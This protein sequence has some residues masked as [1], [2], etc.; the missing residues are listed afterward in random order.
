MGNTV[1]DPD[2]Q[3]RGGG[4]GREREKGGPSLKK[5]FSAPQA[6][7]WS[8]NKGGRVPWAPPLDLLLEYAIIDI[9]RDSRLA[10]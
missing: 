2:L 10:T 9:K 7:V 6:S 3:I 1:V 4:G 8:K 5:P